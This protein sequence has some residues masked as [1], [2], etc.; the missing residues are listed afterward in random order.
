MT[1]Q[2]YHIPARPN[3]S[4]PADN[5]IT[6]AGGEESRG[7][8]FFVDNFFYWKRIYNFADRKNGDD[9]IVFHTIGRS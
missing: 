4:F 7:C 8:Y 5:G 6:P 9:R 1:L 2:N 3:Q